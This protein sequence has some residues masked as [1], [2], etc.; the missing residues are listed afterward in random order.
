MKI[1]RVSAAGWFLVVAAVAFVVYGTTTMFTYVAQ[2]P[3]AAGPPIG[4][5]LW[6]YRVNY[7]CEP[8]EAMACSRMDW[9][10]QIC[11]SWRPC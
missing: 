8:G 9:T 7:G 3:D 6:S 5:K 2:P 4:F 11:V 1:D 10:G